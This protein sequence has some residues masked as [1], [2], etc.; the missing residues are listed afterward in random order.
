MSCRGPDD[1]LA[2]CLLCHTMKPAFDDYRLEL[3][4]LTADEGG[5]WLAAFPDLPGCMADGETPEAAI[6][7]ARGA[8]ACWMAAHVADG[9]A[10]PVPSGG[11]DSGLFSV[12]V[13]KSMHIQLIA[14][15]GAK[16][17]R[18]HPHR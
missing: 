10:I 9:R 1:I 2:F 15:S 17:Q 14:C 7:D 8:F 4:P 16:L 13:P 18:T 11:G 5:G 3:R 6:A 12:R